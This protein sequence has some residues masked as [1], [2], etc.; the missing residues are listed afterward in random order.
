M[1]SV[2]ESCRLNRRDRLRRKLMG[3]T[4][5]DGRAA[6]RREIRE[7]KVATFALQLRAQKQTPPEA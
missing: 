6:Q 3:E 4:I 7:V 5:D 2:A 1:A